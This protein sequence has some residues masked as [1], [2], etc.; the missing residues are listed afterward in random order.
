LQR[1]QAKWRSSWPRDG[2]VGVERNLAGVEVNVG[3]RWR[4]QRR[5]TDKPGPSPRRHRE[6]ALGVG[7]KRHAAVAKSVERDRRRGIQEW[8]ESRRLYCIAGAARCS[9][10]RNQGKGR[11]AHETVSES[12]A[13]PAPCVR[14][15]IAADFFLCRF[16]IRV[17]DVR[18]LLAYSGRSARRNAGTRNRPRNRSATGCAH[19]HGSGNADRRES[20]SDRPLDDRREAWG[21][22]ACFGGFA[23]SP[24]I[25]AELYT[26]K[27]HKCINWLIPEL[28]SPH[29]DDPTW[30]LPP[31]GDEVLDNCPVQSSLPPGAGGCEIK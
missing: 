1:C 20:A 21:E 18:C 5:G 10:G 24:Y 31:I 25:T 16:A 22:T 2:H 23:I 13:E 17:T 30:A 3:D 9:A 6:T 27:C 14:D 11:R 29:V 28:V 15:R 26:I 4:E 19:R 8:R 7:G 12:T